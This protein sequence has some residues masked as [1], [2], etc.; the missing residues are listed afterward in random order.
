M[1]SNRSVKQLIIEPG[2]LGVNGVLLTAAG[3]STPFG[4]LGYNQLTVEWVV[5]RVAATDLS[6]YITSSMNQGTSYGRFKF[7]DVDPATGI[8]TL[9]HLQLVDP[10]MAT[11]TAGSFQMP[12]NCEWLRL[13]AI[14]GA[15]ATTD[16]VRM[17]VTLG[18]V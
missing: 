9:R 6:F 10:N 16:T 8:M 17:R 11:A 3:N 5:T 18:V 1:P 7:G 2:P 12:L 4:C 13:D 14:T 15:A